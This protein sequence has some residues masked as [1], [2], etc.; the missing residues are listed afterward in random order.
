[1]PFVHWKIPWSCF[2]ST[3]NANVE[4]LNHSIQLKF[5]KRY[6]NHKACG[7]VIQEMEQ[8]SNQYADNQVNPLFSDGRYM[9]E[10][11]A[12]ALQKQQQQHYHMEQQ[13]QMEQQM[14]DQ[15]FSNASQ[16]RM[17]GLQNVAGGWR[18]DENGRR[19]YIQGYIQ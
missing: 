17:Q 4:K 18:I 8:G 14:M 9:S 19:H 3:T 15:A 13:Y 12:V 2:Q 11:D 1:V 6:R 7:P 16:A 5:E 10:N